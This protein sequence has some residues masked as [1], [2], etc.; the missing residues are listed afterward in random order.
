[1][2]VLLNFSQVKNVEVR[3]GYN[4]FH[5]KCLVGVVAVVP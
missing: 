3:P 5:P 4:E 1:M 2:E